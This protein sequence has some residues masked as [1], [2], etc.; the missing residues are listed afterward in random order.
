[1]SLS[2]QQ[3]L[4]LL[5]KH[6]EGN[7][8]DDELSCLKEEIKHNNNLKTI[9]L[10][11]ESPEEIP[12]LDIEAELV[13]EKTRP[14]SLSHLSKDIPRQ[15][16]GISIKTILAIVALLA[17]FGFVWLTFKKGAAPQRDG[18]WNV[19]KTAKGERK[20]F[21]LI[22][23]TSIWLNNESTLSVKEG[24]GK[25]HREVLL[26]GEAYFDVARNENLPL[27][28]YTEQTS[29]EVLG[30]VFN[31]RSYPEDKA[32]E[33]SLIEGKIKLTVKGEKKPDYTL[34]PGDRVI[35]TKVSSTD[36]S[37]I[38]Q[39]SPE[40][41]KMQVHYKKM[42]LKS[43]DLVDF[44]WIDNQLVFNGDPLPVMLQKLSRWYNKVIILETT[45][46]EQEEFSG[47]FNEA[48][49]EQVLDILRKT[50]AKLNYET[51][52]DTIYIK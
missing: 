19:V 7:L 37:P 48:E 44:K 27:H 52:R 20:F 29:I 23:G 46:L 41:V 9:L 24:Y 50:G 10:Y 34:L 47:V 11:L 21:K 13:Y 28:V 38:K 14:N 45:A 33:A 22:D 36:S 8:T 39:V 35:V 5:Q 40:T 25:R 6:L 49:C 4:D 16:K 51:K 15:H 32:T 17:L 43:K 2:E 3:I 30:T 31:V 1:M 42:D 18:K 26:I 12:Y